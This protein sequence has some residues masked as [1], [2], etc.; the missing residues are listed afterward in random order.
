MSIGHI[1]VATDFSD[2]S[3][4]AVREAAAW[5]KRTGAQ[6]TLMH[7]LS[8]PDL[9]PDELEQPIPEH[10]ELEE[11]VHEHLDRIVKSILAGCDAKTAMIRH[12]N[13]AVGIVE[14]A[15][16]L[17][18]DLLIIATHGRSGLAR[19]L[20]GSVAERVVRLA[21]CPVLTVRT[22]VGD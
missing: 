21:S 2:P 17:E 14:L 7:A 4:V 15:K 6:V 10:A 12:T 19:L 18:A 5:A 11:A 3:E 9:D 1:L 22:S 20:L 16:E 8:V 13:P